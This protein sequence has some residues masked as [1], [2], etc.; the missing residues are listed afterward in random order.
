MSKKH[1]VAAARYIKELVGKGEEKEV[2]ACFH[3][4]CHIQ[5]NP[6]FD[7]WRFKDACGLGA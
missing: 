2:I 5:D 6:A 3:L 4:I 1:F 7:R